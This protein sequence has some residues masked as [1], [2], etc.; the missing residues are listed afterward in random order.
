[1]PAGS[2][3]E[4]RSPSRVASPAS[5]ANERCTE[6]RV[7]NRTVTQKRPGA[8]LVSTPRSGSR[9][10]A[11][12]TSTRRA[13]GATWLVATRDRASMRRSLPATRAVSC[14]T[15]ALL[16]GLLRPHRRGVDLAAGH[17]HHAAGEGPGP[18]E[19]V[20]R[21]QHR[22]PRGDGLAHEGVEE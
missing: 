13:N 21:H 10:K 8:A 18:V 20:R 15:D 11:N 3:P 5:M 16:A 14:H 6:R 19:L 4:S 12:S 2:S 17:R 1:M 7:A 22:G 9:A